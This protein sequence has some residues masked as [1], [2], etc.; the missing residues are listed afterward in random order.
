M[1]RQDIPQAMTASHHPV[2]DPRFPAGRMEGAGNKKGADTS[3][4]CASTTIMLRHVVSQTE[5]DD[6]FQE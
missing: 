6:H 5:I 4:R 2:H 1:F 3:S